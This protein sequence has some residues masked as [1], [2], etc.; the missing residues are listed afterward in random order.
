MDSDIEK[1]ADLFLERFEKVSGALSLRSAVSL[2]EVV[3]VL[4]E[5]DSVDARLKGLLAIRSLRLLGGTQIMSKLYEGLVGEQKSLDTQ[6]AI[7][8][9]VGSGGVAFFAIDSRPRMIQVGVPSESLK[10]FL[11]RGLPVPTVYVLPPED[12]P[13]CGDM[14]FPLFW[15]F[16]IQNASQDKSKR[17]VVIGKKEQLEK[18]KVRK[19]K[20]V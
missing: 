3:Q 7:E 8:R 4:R 13:S 16:F 2:S 9:L 14:E 20:Q 10:V 1:L 6:G 17:V 18:V 12:C 5:H 15:N 11:R 19:S